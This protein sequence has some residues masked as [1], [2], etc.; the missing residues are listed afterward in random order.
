MHP[1]PVACE[2][3]VSGKPFGMNDRFRHGTEDP[4]AGARSATTATTDTRLHD[5]ETRVADGAQT[6][7]TERE[8]RRFDREEAAT[9]EP[10][11]AARVE[12]EHRSGLAA[13]TM[14][15]VRA[16]QREEFGGIHW[17]SAFF[18][19]LS[20]L[21]LAAILTGIVSAAGATLEFTDTTDA[22]AETIGLAGGIA[23]LV[24]ALIAYFAGG[25][26]AGRMSRFDGARQGLGVWLIALAVIV[27]L[28][29]AGT[30][31]GAE[32]NVLERLDLPRIPVDEGDIATGAGIAALV[33]ILGS[34]LAAMAGGKAGER[35][36]RKVDRVAIDP[37]A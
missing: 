35:Y 18:G 34:L 12:H 7:D 31:L 8:A 33:G 3:G 36:H 21:G 20:A 16:R 15:D 6:Q 17:G 1:N 24:V 28:A 19:W 13:G 22:G 27:T 37:R 29:V 5:P 9:R 2:L 26:V 23:M 10:A 14:R 25:Y 4:D 11:G 32:Y 30:I